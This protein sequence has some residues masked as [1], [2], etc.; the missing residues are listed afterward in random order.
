[1][2]ELAKLI[3]LI[4]GFASPIAQDKLQRNELVIKLLKKLNLDPDH[5]PADFTAVYQYTLVE[6]GIGKPKP[7]L[8]MFRQA[9]IQEIF[10]K[11]LDQNN[12]SLLL[13]EGETFLSGHTLGEQIKELG[14]DARREFYQ[15]AAVFI[16]VAKRTRTPAEV[17]TN[18]KLESL[19][20]QIGSIQERL[21]RLPTLEGMRTEMARLAAQNYPVLPAAIETPA[22][23]QEKQCRAFAL[24][25]QMKGWFE[26][27]GYRFESHETWQDDYFEWIID[28]PVRRG[29]YDRILVRGIDGEVGLRDIK[30][31]RQSVE[32]HRTDEGWLVTARRISRAAREEV[33]KEENH[34]LGCYTFDELLDQDADFSGYLDWLE[35]EIQRRDHLPI[36][37]LSN[38]T[39]WGNCC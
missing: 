26:T 24:A 15:F 12:P 13:K 28:I 31:L 9:E 25:Q 29:R 3:D 4:V 27:L 22:S 32:A 30:A 1:M 19:H 10:R 23:L 8:D 5:P 2:I 37:P 6:Y 11:A 7:V 16:E 14:I 39:A 33:E 18:Q 17:L 20:R 34:D 35:S 21:H 38:S 36:Q